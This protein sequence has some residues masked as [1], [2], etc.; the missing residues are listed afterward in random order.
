VHEAVRQLP[1]RPRVQWS[2]TLATNL[3]QSAS[4]FRG[5][6]WGFVALGAVALVLTCTA[7]H[8]IV[9]FSLAQRR[10]ELAIRMA[11][12]A[13]A[14]G[15][16]R[17]LLGR[18]ARQLAIGGLLGALLAVA[19][20][21]FMD[22]LPMDVPRAGLWRPTAMMALIMIAGLTACVGPLRRALAIKPLEWLRGE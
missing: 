19:I 6:G 18:T 12:G 5:I 17:A 2:H 8:A 4:L 21:Q 11:L 20:N 15:V 9:A 22:V 13:G 10:R 3:A 14:G 16:L 7:I 1:L